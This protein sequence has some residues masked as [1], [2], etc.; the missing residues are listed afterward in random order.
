MRPEETTLSWQKSSR[1]G[2]EGGNCVEVARLASGV[3]VRDSKDTEGPVLRFVPTA[4]VAFV[5]A[6]GP[7]G[8]VPG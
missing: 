3:A 5:T 8:G 2:G 1:S 6:L 4:W 7:D